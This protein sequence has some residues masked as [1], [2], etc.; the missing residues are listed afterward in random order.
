MANV[1]DGDGGTREDLVQRIALME[2]MIAEG[3]QSTMRYAWIFI[4]WGLVDLAAMAWRY[5]EPHS[6]W[7]GQWAW[8]FCL[9]AGAVA[10]IAGLVLRRGQR[11]N[12]LSMECRTLEAV[13]GMM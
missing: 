4:L 5:F 1:E 10:T 7:V 2:T 3:R 12:A 6:E 11:G 9:V 13:W 8:P